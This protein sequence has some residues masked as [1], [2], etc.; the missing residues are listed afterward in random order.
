MWDIPGLRIKPESPALAGGFF[1]TKPHKPESPALAGGFFATKPPG[2]PSNLN[3]LI[4]AK[5]WSFVFE[6]NF[7]C[8]FYSMY[9]N[10]NAYLT[11]SYG[12]SN[13]TI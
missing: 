8:N 10:K 5:C 7:L 13:T 2:K 12:M 1:A 4:T 9:K 3:F 6:E 11:C